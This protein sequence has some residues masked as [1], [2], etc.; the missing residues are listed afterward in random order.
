LELISPF[1]NSI[2]RKNYEWQ[3][4]VRT[5][6]AAAPPPLFM[7]KKSPLVANEVFPSSGL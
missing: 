5:P 7:E 6:A 2:E 4:A 1:E 3:I